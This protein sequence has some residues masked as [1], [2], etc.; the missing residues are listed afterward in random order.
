MVTCKKTNAWTQ[1]KIMAANVQGG[2]GGYALQ[3]PIQ[4][5][6]A[7]KWYLFQAAGK[8]KDRE[9]TGLSIRKGR[10]IRHFGL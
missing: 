3:W 1:F 10:E 8:W 7:Q 2:G 4:E 6:S 5:G 9:F